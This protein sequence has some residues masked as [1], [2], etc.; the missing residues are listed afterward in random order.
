MY[1]K[2]M[3]QYLEKLA[4]LE[5]QMYT[6]KQLY[7]DLH[8]ESERLGKPRKIQ[9]PKAPEKD[10]PETLGDSIVRILVAI[11]GVAV[12]SLGIWFGFLILSMLLPTLIAVLAEMIFQIEDIFQ[13]IYF[14]EIWGWINFEVTPYLIPALLTVAAVYLWVDGRKK[15]RKAYQESM[16]AYQESMKAYEADVAA[17]AIRV[18]QEL[19]V[20]EVLCAQR[21]AVNAEYW[22]TKDARDALYDLGII[23]K[24]YRDFAAVTTFY[25]YFRK[26][27]CTRLTGPRQAYDRYDE[28]LRLGEIINKLDVIIQKLDEISRKQDYIAD[29]LRDANNTIR[30]IEQTNKPMLDTMQRIEENTELTAYN[31]ECT[32]RSSEV[33]ALLT[34]YNTLNQKD[35]D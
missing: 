2:L 31:T 19:E 16:E 24:E 4:Q 17:D 21:D 10:K 27:Y 6:L 9:K 5:C 26:E 12:I 15:V 1:R 30:R 34:L 3:M 29:L 22:K 25:S 7:W 23:E 18:Q 33:T 14:D 8:N 28:E 20:K 13:N 35:N 32:A 11:I